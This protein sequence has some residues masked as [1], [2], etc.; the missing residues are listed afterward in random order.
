MAATSGIHFK[1]L[2]LLNAC[3]EISADVISINLLLKK[4]Q[5]KVLVCTET[6]PLGVTLCWNGKESSVTQKREIIA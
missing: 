4:K 5:S 6:Q 2:L 1:L 3:I